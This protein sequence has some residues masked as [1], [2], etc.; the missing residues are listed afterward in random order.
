MKMPNLSA[1]ARSCS[2][3]ESHV[4]IEAAIEKRPAASEACESSFRFPLSSGVFITNILAERLLSFGARR[5]FGCA[6]V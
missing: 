3:V 5:Y 2:L 6:K 1:C 4:T